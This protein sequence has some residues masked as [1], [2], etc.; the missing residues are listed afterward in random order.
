ML[1]PGR[2][3][4]ALRGL[5][6]GLGQATT[7]LTVVPRAC[8]S[9]GAAAVLAVREGRLPRVSDVEARFLP[10]WFACVAADWLQG[11]FLFALYTE[12]GCSK[13]VIARLFA[14]GFLSSGILGSV[15][16]GLCDV[17]GRR[18]GCL[19]YCWLA[20]VSCLLTH[21][22]AVVP[23]AVGRLLGG[24]AESLLY[25]AFEVWAISE[26]GRHLGRLG[27]PETATS[28]AAAECDAGEARG[29]T[30]A[31]QAPLSRLLGRM[32]LGSWIVAVLAGV[33]ASGVVRAAPP[34]RWPSAG[35]PSLAFGGPTAAF[36]LAAG[37]CVL[38]A[39]LISAL[40]GRREEV[41]AR[42]TP[43]PPR[44]LR[45]RPGAWRAQQFDVRALAG[46][47]AVLRDRRMVLCGG[48]VAAFEGSMFVFVFS[49]SPVLVAGSPGLAPHLGLIFSAF[50]LSCAFGSSAFERLSARM[51][52]SELI[53]PVLGLASL[54][55][56]GAAS[57]SR[58]GP[59]GVPA[60]LACFLAFELCIGIYFPC[61]SA[62]KSECVPEEIRSLTYSLYRVPLNALALAVLLFVPSSSN[63]L[64]I[65]ATTLAMVA[66]L[67]A[68]Q[69]RRLGAKP[70]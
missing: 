22:T 40:W 51:A 50:M 31:R 46:A 35:R 34:R 41:E 32:W 2:D 7:P 64:G 18:R 70:T 8:A 67:A 37:F 53:A 43:P 16:G 23:L 19:L 58:A 59:A 33:A 66:V 61:I 10:V 44:R 24:V 65:C 57:A 29:R 62:L 21:S 9:A 45:C 52:A 13:S 69:F 25:S 15:A 47:S 6:V 28:A 36:D 20:F 42:P 12:R 48:I 38:G 39:V 49:W 26:H 4:V 60:A 3:V 17:I 27:P 30:S 55:L 5:G 56:A 11:P 68:S 14:V 54:A 1:G 63:A